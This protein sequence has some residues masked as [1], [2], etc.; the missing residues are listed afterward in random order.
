MVPHGGDP[1]SLRYNGNLVAICVFIFVEGL[2][3]GLVG[4]IMVDIDGGRHGRQ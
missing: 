1:I 4:G 2:T 3:A